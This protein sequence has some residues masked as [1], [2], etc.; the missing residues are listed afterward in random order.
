MQESKPDDQTSK[1]P[2]IVR[3]NQAILALRFHDSL[4][5]THPHIQPSHKLHCFSI[6]VGLSNSSQPRLR[7]AQTLDTLAGLKDPLSFILSHNKSLP[8]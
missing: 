4:H 8:D 5:K 3:S 7:E 1:E 2:S 6:F